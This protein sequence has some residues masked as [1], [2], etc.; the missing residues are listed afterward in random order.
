M[1]P[2]AEAPDLLLDP[3]SNAS[4][5]AR[6]LHIERKH[7]IGEAAEANGCGRWAAEEIRAVA[8]P[9]KRRPMR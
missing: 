4:A 5:A 6:D 2:A 3:G 9:S 8:P 1:E 7:R